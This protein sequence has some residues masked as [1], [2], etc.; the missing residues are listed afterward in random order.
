M[1]FVI[2]LFVTLLIF[3]CQKKL[4]ANFDNE[5]CFNLKEE[6]N[7]YTEFKPVDQKI[8]L[9]K[10][11][12][13]LVFEEIKNATAF[14]T[15]YSGYT[16]SFSD[17]E[18]L[19]SPNDFQYLRKYNYQNTDYYLA[20]NDF[21]YWLIEYVSK[22]ETPY[23]LGVATDKYIHIKN[24][25]KFPLI[26]LGKFQVECAFI[27]LYEQEIQL[28]SGPKYEAVK[29]NLLVKINLQTIKKDSDQDG[30]ND[31]EDSNPLYKSTKSDFTFL[32]EV[33]S[34]DF[35]F[36][37]KTI[38]NEEIEKARNGNKDQINLKPFIFSVYFSDCNYFKSIN[39]VSKKTLILDKNYL[40]KKKFSV[41]NSFNYS[42]FSLFKKLDD[43]QVEI[44]KSHNSGSAT[45]KCDKTNNGWKIS[46]TQ[47]VSI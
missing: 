31:F 28:F 9:H 35:D 20:Q 8:I 17:V 18:Q 30:F 19:L 12:P 23:F 22:I 33:L 34:S 14:D 1:K 13:N 11:Y 45:F 29:D 10:E 26:S 15:N 25:E 21:G 5:K 42:D 6:K 32:F 40:G 2:L 37:D 38:S 4:N 3:S 43:D 41:G 27:R 46:T 36:Y 44:R 47:M 24:S 7:N 39:P 16:P